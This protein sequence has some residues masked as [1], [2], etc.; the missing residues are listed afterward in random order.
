M[1]KDRAS[2]IVKSNK[3]MRKALVKCVL[4]YLVLILLSIVTGVV[5]V[6]A[7]GV[8]RVSPLLFGLIH[9]VLVIAGFITARVIVGKLLRHALKLSGLGISMAAARPILFK[10][11]LGIL[12]AEAVIVI[13][14]LLMS[15][16]MFNSAYMRY[17]GFYI[18]NSLLAQDKVEENL[19][20]NPFEFEYED[21]NGN[22]WTLDTIRK[23]GLTTGVSEVDLL[24]KFAENEAKYYEENNIAGGQKYWTWA[25]NK[26]YGTYGSAWEWCAN[27]VT[28][29]VI[30][31]GLGESAESTFGDLDGWI[32]GGGGY[33]SCTSWRAHM[34]KLGFGEHKASSGYTPQPGDIVIYTTQGEC[35]HI[36]IV[37][38]THGTTMTTIEGN[39]GG[40]R[41]K[42]TSLV[43]VRDKRPISGKLSSWDGA[44]YFTPPYKITG[45]TSSGEVFTPGK[46]YNQAETEEVLYKFLSE[47]MGLNN[48]ACAGIIANIYCESHFSY[49]QLEVANYGRVYTAKSKSATS[50]D[51]PVSYGNNNYAGLSDIDKLWNYT[52]KLYYENKKSKSGY[53]LYGCGY[54]I[55][56]WSFTNRTNYAQWSMANG[57][58]PG[59]G[60]TSLEGQCMYLKYQLENSYQSLLELMKTV[61]N[62]KDG[63][64]Q[65]GEMWCH[66][67]ERPAGHVADAPSNYAKGCSE[68]TRRGQVASTTYWEKYGNGLD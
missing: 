6:Y 39:T 42:Y 61:P 54:G 67:F 45:T 30:E 24:L 31:C 60:P 8:S 3:S 26:G 29:C 48:A 65:V 41:T 59:Y 18:H 47:T 44:V 43:A 13:A 23:G 32:R 52:G 17:F 34:R 53:T 66:R 2:S 10:I 16:V 56:G 9:L 51:A 63:A 55:V 38:E 5:F 1:I 22:A 7:S 20:K 57:Y 14:S 37:K 36:G 4:V 46:S 49:D 40:G 12:I 33:L 15:I 11:D 50:F 62:T 28:Y 19:K 68:C 58:G 21:E 64:L 27:F 35:Q 25:K